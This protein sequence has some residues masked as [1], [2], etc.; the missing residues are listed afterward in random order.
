MKKRFQLDRKW[1]NAFCSVVIKRYLL[2]LSMVD[3]FSWLLLE[4]REQSYPMQQYI[5]WKASTE[6]WKFWKKRKFMIILPATKSIA[7][8]TGMSRPLLPMTTPNSTSWW[9]TLTVGGNSIGSPKND[10]QSQ[11]SSF[12]RDFDCWRFILNLIEHSSTLVWEKWL[13]SSELHYSALK[14]IIPI[15]FYF[16]TT[17]CYFWLKLKIKP[18][19]WSA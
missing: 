2:L 18:C 12:V 7:S 13:A 11:F 1:T 9:S 16:K 6:I 15:K 5:L 4:Y 3:L 17:L 10:S 14:W 19:A 8:F